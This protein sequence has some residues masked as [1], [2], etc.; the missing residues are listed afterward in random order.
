MLRRPSFR[1]LLG[2]AA[3]AATAGPAPAQRRPEFLDPRREEFENLPEPDRTIFPGDRFTFC[4][5]RFTSHPGKSGGPWYTD[6]P[7]SD[8]NFPARLAEL[9][10]LD[11]NPEPV[12]ARLTDDAL[13]NYPFLYLIEAGSLELSPEEAARLREYLL[14]GGF[15]L[16]DD[17]WGEEEWANWSEQIAKALPP[18]EYPMKDIPPDHELFHIVFN[19]KEVPQVPSIHVW[20]YRG[21]TWERPD[22]QKAHCRGIFDKK[23]RLMTVIMHNTDLGDGWEREGENEEYFREFSATK[24]YPMGVNIVVYAMTH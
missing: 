22:A 13:F 21:V 17:F 16:V 24:A 12:V 9:T 6:Y 7:D 19:L 8:L 23:G 15:L 11:V 18:D 5:V 4:R 1:F 10:T 14:R 3:L 2:I 20:A